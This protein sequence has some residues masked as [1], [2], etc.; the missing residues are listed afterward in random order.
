MTEK[1]EIFNLEW[2]LI[3]IENRKEFYTKIK[4]EF[5][6]TWEITK[7]VKTIRVLLLN[8]F[9]RIYLQ[10]R[11]NTKSENPWMYDKTV[12]WHVSAWDSFN[13]TAI[14]ECAEE[15]WFP[16]TIMEDNEF[17]NSI[18]STDLSIIWI[19]KK[20]D[21]IQTF[22]SKRVNKDWTYFIQPQ[23][24][25]IYLW[26]YDWPIKFVDWECSWIEVFSIDELKNEIINNPNKFTEDLKVI[27]DKY[28]DF[29]IK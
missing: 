26:Y 14:K 19:F 4:E 16:M 22:N 23:I 5:K 3:S 8:S 24:T 15:L 29:L 12:W 9:G 18:K 21:Y 25:T 2:D 1:L 17:E 20:I 28:K 11:S 27:I 6:N 7:K 10:K 13:L